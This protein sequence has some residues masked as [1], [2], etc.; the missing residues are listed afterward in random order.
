MDHYSRRI[1]GITLFEREPTSEAV[2]AFL[3]R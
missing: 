1:V 3:G 2:R